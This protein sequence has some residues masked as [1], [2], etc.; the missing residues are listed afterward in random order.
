MHPL[1]GVL[2]CEYVRKFL[3]NRKNVPPCELPKAISNVVSAF[4][5]EYAADLYFFVLMQLRKEIVSPILLEQQGRV[6]GLG[7]AERQYFH[8]SKIAKYYL[9]IFKKTLKKVK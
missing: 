2:V 9:K 5:F 6:F 3:A 7:Y 4:P 8:E 1:I